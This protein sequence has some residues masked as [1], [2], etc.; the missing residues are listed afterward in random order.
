[1]EVCCCLLDHEITCFSPYCLSKVGFQHRPPAIEARFLEC[2]A[3]IA[4]HSNIPLPVK[5]ESMICS[6]TV[7]ESRVKENSINGKLEKEQSAKNAEP[8]N[9]SREEFRT[10]PSPDQSVSSENTST[11]T[12]TSN[13]TENKKCWSNSAIDE[14]L[15]KE[16]ENYKN[17]DVPVIH[18][19]VMP[20]KL[21]KSASSPVS[22]EKCSQDSPCKMVPESV[23]VPIPILNTLLDRILQTMLDS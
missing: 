10:I 5:D 17:S 3:A 6:T 14:E 15:C 16:L 12:S 13:E 7:D 23:A 20:T 18:A 19:F 2:M 9:L 1:M 21:S 4:L 22:G 8:G 11:T